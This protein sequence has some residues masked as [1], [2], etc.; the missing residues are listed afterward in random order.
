[1][2]VRASVSLCVNVCVCVYVSVYVSVCVF[3][4]EFECVCVLKGGCLSKVGQNLFILRGGGRT[5]F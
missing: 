5:N 1:M 4:F 3:V 2:C